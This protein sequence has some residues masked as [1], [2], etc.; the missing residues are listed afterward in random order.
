MLGCSWL[1]VCKLVTEVG[2][3]GAAGGWGFADFRSRNQR[4]TV[5][6]RF[7]KVVRMVVTPGDLLEARGRTTMAPGPV[8]C[9]F[10]KAHY[11]HVNNMDAVTRNLCPRLHLCE[12]DGGS[13]YS[14]QIS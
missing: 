2:G 11:A 14:T 4:Q 12:L 7:H 8:G 1:H 3:S 9:P 10:G 13:A 5:L 6:P